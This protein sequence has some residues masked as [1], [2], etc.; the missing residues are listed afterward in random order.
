MP[1][2][3]KLAGPLHAMRIAR[4][5]RRRVRTRMTVAVGALILGMLAPLSA[6]QN[7][8]PLPSIASA[9]V[10]F[11][12]RLPQKAHI[13]GVIRL[14]ITTDGSRPSSIEIVSGQP[15]LARAATENVEAWEFEQH[16]PTIFETVFRYRLLPSKCDAACKCT[17]VEDPTV[18][19]RLPA[20]VEITAAQVWI[21]HPLAESEN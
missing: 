11:Y 13:E 8:E 5:R 2:P 7:R 9:R 10:P 3:P 1:L 6:A 17:S 18:L 21:C 15:M 4:K 14:R 19:L 12:P 16:Q 20:E